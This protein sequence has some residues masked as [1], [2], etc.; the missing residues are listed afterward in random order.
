MPWAALIKFSFH[1]YY[2]PYCPFQNSKSL[3]TYIW[4]H[5]IW[6]YLHLP[7]TQNDISHTLLHSRNCYPY[8]Q[9]SSHISNYHP[10]DSMLIP[11]PLIHS[12]SEMWKIDQSS[13]QEVQMNSNQLKASPSNTYCYVRKLQAKTLSR[14]KQ[15]PKCHTSTTPNISFTIYLLETMHFISVSKIMTKCL[16]WCLLKWTKEKLPICNAVALEVLLCVLGTAQHLRWTVVIF[17]HRLWV[18]DLVLVV[19]LLLSTKFYIVLF[20][21]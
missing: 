18:I 10:Y 6:I 1:N 19:F 12:V 5:Y 7:G 11:P 4:I 14:E 21:G 20:L 13:Y 3:E 8:F 15:Q 17:Y 9:R 16:G 2:I